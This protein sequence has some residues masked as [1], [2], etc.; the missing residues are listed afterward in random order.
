MHL[1]QTKARNQPK[2]VEEKVKSWELT[3]P[4]IVSTIRS[5]SVLPSI[6]AEVHHRPACCPCPWSC[7][8]NMLL[9]PC[10][11]LG[12]ELTPCIQPRF[13]RALATMTSSYSF[14]YINTHYALLCSVYLLTSTNPP[15]KLS[16]WGW[17]ITTAAK[18]S[19][20]ER[21]ILP[22]QY[23]C[24]ASLVRTSQS[25]KT[26]ERAS[27][28]SRTRRAVWLSNQALS[29]FGAS[30][31]SFAGIQANGIHDVAWVLTPSWKLRRHPANKNIWM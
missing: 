7:F 20:D 22:P 12:P 27:C 9:D 11:G 10:S 30:L 29:R 25:L 24:I 2:A 15:T 23:S 28:S 8:L 1:K 31:S 14:R 26:C 17:S 19:F 21:K 5:R 3:L 13:G 6:V 4:L 16:C 18:Y